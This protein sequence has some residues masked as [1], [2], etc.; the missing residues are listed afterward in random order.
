MEPGGYAG[1]DGS[2]ATEG[3]GEFCEAGVEL[4]LDGAV[5]LDGG[6]LLPGAELALEG[7]MG[8]LLVIVCVWGVGGEVTMYHR[9]SHNNAPY[10]CSHFSTLFELIMRTI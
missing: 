9:F 1:V 6:E 4:G 10:F 8:L 5:D 3:L 2:A 7:V